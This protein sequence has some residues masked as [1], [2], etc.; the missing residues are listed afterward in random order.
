MQSS[1][2][3]EYLSLVERHSIVKRVKRDRLNHNPLLY[4]WPHTEGCDGTKCW[5]NKNK[6]VD[7]YGQAYEIGGCPQY[8]FH[9]SLADVRTFFG[10]NQSGKTTA[11]IV[12]CGFHLTGLY[13]DWYPIERRYNYPIVG[14]VLA[15]DFKKAVGEVITKA[16]DA[17]IPKS[18]IVDKSRSSQGIYD[19]YW[20]RHKSGGISSFDII[21]YEQD[22]SVAEGWVG[23]FAWY[24]EPPPHQHYIATSR[25]LMQQ[26]GWS[27]FTLTPLKEPWLFDSLWSKGNLIEVKQ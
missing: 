20:V 25:G 7:A 24:D 1:K 16:I 6:Y 21:T 27:I 4:Y 15:N 23:K 3:K 2:E 5:S 22:S 17:W 10:S 14:R 13:P 12:E 26:E 18:L 11:G 9:T 8:F 19:K